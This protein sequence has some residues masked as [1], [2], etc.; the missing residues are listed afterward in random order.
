MSLT[1]LY[2][3]RLREGL[4]LAQETLP[5]EAQTVGA[6]LEILRARGGQWQDLLHD[7]KNLRVAVN[8]DLAANDTPLRDGDEVALF[9]PVTGG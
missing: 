6:L 8:Q 4:G 7:G 9:P 3:A 1:V 5:A 2:F